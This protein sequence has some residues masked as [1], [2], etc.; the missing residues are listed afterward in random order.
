MQNSKIEWTDHTFNPWVGCAKV[1]PGCDHCYAAELNKRFKKVVWGEPGV[2]GTRNLTSDSYW[3]KPLVWNRKAKREGK[4]AK[5]FCAS[6]ADVFDND[7]PEGAHE[8]LWKLIE[9]TPYLAWQLLT[10]RPQNI[11]RLVPEDW[12]RAGFPRNVWL[13][14]SCENQEEYERRWGYVEDCD[15]DVRFISYEPAIGPLRLRDP[16]EMP[17]N[18]VIL[19]GES[20][21]N[22]RPCNP[23][24]FRNLM[25]DCRW[26]L[27]D[28]VEGSIPFFLKQWGSW[29]NNPV[30]SES[31]QPVETAKA[32]DLDPEAKGGATL[33]GRLFRRF[34]HARFSYQPP[35]TVFAR[36]K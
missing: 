34:P 33:D 24:W 36:A 19:G 26:P 5:V 17:P 20:G 16:W 23:Q 25:D 27:S 13:G 14:V 4:I 6:M 18:W 15:V 22:A 12:V 8:R 35:T 21:T 29:S 1:S 10:K 2:R 32:F 3:Q 31:L 11:A 9:D 30:V 7:A 28:T